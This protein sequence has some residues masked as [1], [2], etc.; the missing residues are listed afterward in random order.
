M[1]K[2]PAKIIKIYLVRHGELA[3]PQKIIYGFLPLPLTPRGR[4]QA[5]K[6]GLFFKDKDIKAIFSSPQR[7]CQ[8]TAKIIS[9]A[10]SKG[11][12][13]VETQ[14]NLRESSLGHFAEG[15]TMRQ[16]KEKYP[17]IFRHYRFKPASV[18]AGGENLAK[19][20]DR[21]LKT[22]RASVKKYPGQNLVFVSHRD[23]ILATLLKISG[24]SLNDLHKVKG[25]CGF[26]AVYEL[27][28]L[29]KKL[30]NKTYLS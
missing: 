23:P 9:Q 7:R 28:L 26:G 29:G 13:R 1:K 3:N 30:V 11:R 27:N 4:T 25:I 6:A 19:M 14:K 12:I 20:A 2:P 15:L 5:K 22:V 10:I 8:E 17:K 24:R 18:N 21:V 16:A